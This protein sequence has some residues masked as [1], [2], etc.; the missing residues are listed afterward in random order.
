MCKLRRITHRVKPE[1][2]YVK[3]VSE[4]PEFTHRLNPQNNN[5]FLIIPTLEQNSTFVKVC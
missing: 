5:S 2:L 4:S 3:F 1:G